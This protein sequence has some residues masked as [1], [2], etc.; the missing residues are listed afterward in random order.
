MAHH[1]F[2]PP[3]C[4]AVHAVAALLLTVGCLRA[5]N[6]TSLPTALQEDLGRVQEMLA[7]KQFS[8][9]SVKLEELQK[10]H[11]D[12]ADI[13]NL[14]GSLHLTAEIRDPDAALAAFSKA[15]ELR[16]TDLAPRFNL[17]ELAF[18][19]SDWASAQKDFETIFEDFPKMPLNVR[20]LVVLKL[21]VCH[22]KLG[23]RANA[24]ALISK[25][26][27]FMDD[28]PAYYFAKAA[29][30]Y[31][32]EKEADATEWMAK[33]KF[34]FGDRDGAAYLDTLMEAGWVPRM[35]LSSAQ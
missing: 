8:E 23:A 26:L 12:V 9:A 13:Y 6:P 19:K 4:T 35:G 18:V 14:L 10:N 7:A 5:Q 34:I 16:P 29:L 28:T 3:I 27:T 22:L 17:A 2:L 21:V 11:P 32:A 20:H 30:A 1:L 24:E 31:S 33:A 15:R 25:H